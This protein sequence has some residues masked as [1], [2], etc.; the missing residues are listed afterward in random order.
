MSEAIDESY[1]HCIGKYALVAVLEHIFMCLAHIEL[2]T[3]GETRL[4][5]LCKHCY[6]SG[7]LVQR[8]RGVSDCLLTLCR[9][10]KVDGHIHHGAEEV[11]LQFKLVEWDLKETSS[12]DSDMGRRRLDP[13]SFFVC[14]SF[15]G[16]LLTFSISNRD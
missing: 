12:S 7:S 10:P 16:T 8:N 11:E 15:G 14:N 2:G 9:R 4:A 1:R 6:R 3:V 5:A 13:C